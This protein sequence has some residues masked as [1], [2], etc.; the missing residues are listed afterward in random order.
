M[1]RNFY[2]RNF[3][4]A[5]KII[6]PNLYLDDD[7]DISGVQ[8]KDTDLLINSHILS[9]KNIQETLKLSSSAL[10]GS[11][12]YS[13]INNI[14][15]F[16]QFF[17]KQNKLTNI[18]PEKFQRKILRPMGQKLSS[19]QS[20][21]DFG[22]YVS[23]TLLPKIYL[24][25]TNIKTDT[26]S[27]FGG[28]QLETTEYVISN[29][30]WLYFLNTSAPA[31]GSFAPSTLVASSIVNTLW[32]N[33]PYRLN[34][35]IKDYQTYLWENFEGSSVP[36]EL[37][38]DKF[39]SD[40]GT[41]TSG[42][43][44]LNKLH[45]L[46]DVIYS[47]L[48]IDQEDK[49]VEEAF[50]TYVSATTLLTS[51]EEAGPFHKFL[52]GASLGMYDVNAQ[53][54]GLGDLASIDDCPEEY[55]PLLANLIGWKLYGRN[56]ESW[57]NQLKNAP[58]I[59][60][61]KGTKQGIIDSLNS[62]IPQNPI[63]SSG[64]ITELY[65]SYLPNLIYYCLATGSNLF[66]FDTYTQE[67]AFSH[68]AD[69]YS[70]TDKDYN[71]RV[72]VDNIL[73]YLVEEK[74]DNFIVQNEAFRVTRLVTGKAW[75]G[76][77]IEIAANVWTTAVYG[78][79]GE[80]LYDPKSAVDVDILADP[81]FVFNYRNRD[82]VLPPWEEEKFYSNCVIDD[83]LLA[84]LKT[85]LKSFCVKVTL[86]DSLIEYARDFVIKGSTNTDLYIGNSFIF[87][88]S[89]QHYPP[90][91]A[92]VFG[93]YKED[94]YDYLT[95][96]N[97]KSSLFDFTVSGGNFDAD[98]FQDASGRHTTND[99]L[100]S[101][102]IVDD[103][104]PA[105]AI[106]RV[107]FT[108]AAAE[109]ASG[110][111]FACPSV[112]VG[113]TNYGTSNAEVCG[114]YSRGRYGGHGSEIYPDFTDNLKRTWTSHKDKSTFKRSQFNYRGGQSLYA[115]SIFA[116]DQVV[117]VAS[118]VGRFS[119]RRRNFYNALDQKEWFNRSGNNMP[120]FYN[121]LG[122]V[123]TSNAI[124]DFVKLGFTPSSM[125]FAPPTPE[126]LSGVYRLDCSGSLSTIPDV[127]FGVA[128]KNTF[129]C[130]SHDTLNFS[131]CD[132]YVRR[133]RIPEE[134]KLF[135]DIHEEKKRSIAR[136][137]VTSNRNA[138]AA[139]A[140]WVNF[141]NSFANTIEDTGYEKYYSQTLNRRSINQK[142]TN[143]IYN[144]YA[145]Y[146]SGTNNAGLPENLAVNYRKGGANIL[147][148]T[149]GPIYRNSA[150]NYDGSALEVSSQFINKSIID[151]FLINLAASASVISNKIGLNTVNS[152]TSLNLGG[153][154]E[155]STK[156]IL[157]GINFIDTST[158]TLTPTNQFGI[159]DLVPQDSGLVGRPSYLENNRTVLMRSRS[160]GLPR[161]R[162]GLRGSDEKNV[163]VP[164][165]EYS[166]TLNY[167]TGRDNSSFIGGGSVGVLLHTKRE[168][169]SD[170][171]GVCFVWNKNSEWEQVY[172]SDLQSDTSRELILNKYVHFF[173]DEIRNEGERIGAC[174]DDE[175]LNGLQ[176]I[177]AESFSQAS[178]KFHTINAKT[179][180]TS[181][182]ATNFVASLSSV[183]NGES[184]QVHK[185]SI[186]D[187]NRSQNYFVNVLA[188][189]TTTF[190]DRFV[191][192][193][194]IDMVNE[195]LNNA[196]KV[197]YKAT[198]PDTSK[199]GETYESVTIL[200]P[201]GLELQGLPD[202]QQPLNDSNLMVPSD[203]EL[204]LAATNQSYLFNVPPDLA[205]NYRTTSLPFYLSLYPPGG[206]LL[207]NNIG[208]YYTYPYT[209][210]QNEYYT[211]SKRG[212]NS[213]FFRAS[214]LN[215]G[216]SIYQIR[217]WFR[218]EYLGSRSINLG[219]RP[220]LPT[221]T[222]DKQYRTFGSVNR[223]CDLIWD[224]QQSLKFNSG[225]VETDRNKDRYGFLQPTKIIFDDTTNVGLRNGIVPPDTM[226]NPL[227]YTVQEDTLAPIGT[228][229][230]I[231]QLLPVG[232]PIQS[233]FHS[234]RFNNEYDASP[235]QTDQF[236][237]EV[238]E[239][240]LGKY[241][242]GTMLDAYP[243]LINDL[244]VINKVNYGLSLEQNFGGDSS[245]VRDFNLDK[246]RPVPGYYQDVPARDLL[247][248][249]TYSFSVYLARPHDIT[250]MEG[251]LAEPPLDDYS[252]KA[253]S[254][255]ITLAP[256][257][258]NSS[259]VRL[260]INLNTE[261][262]SIQKGGRGSDLADSI[263]AT[264]EKVPYTVDGQ[265][266]TWYKLKVTLTYDATEKSDTYDLDQDLWDECLSQDSRLA[267]DGLRCSVFAY[268]DQY[269]N[270]L[271]TAAGNEV[272]DISSRVM[273]W[274]PSLV[275]G[276]AAGY[277]ERATELLP[278][279]T[280]P[281]QEIETIVYNV[282]GN[283][284]D[285]GDPTRK[286]TLFQ[287]DDFNLSYISED[288]EKLEK[289]TVAI[290]SPGSLVSPTTLY[291]K[292]FLYDNKQKLHSGPIYYDLARKLLRGDIYAA[293]GDQTNQ[294]KFLTV[295]GGGK[296]T[297]ITKEIESTFRIKPRQLLHLFRY[298]N[299]LGQVDK[300]EGFLTR[301]PSDSAAMH[302]VSGGSRVAYRSHP[303]NDT[304]GTSSTD[305]HSFSN[306]NIIG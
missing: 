35:A 141:E 207:W 44:N 49:R 110:A 33:K 85:L 42:T 171:S 298:F 127:Y 140:S 218:T 294:D 296:G 137:I 299:N 32:N 96:W 215:A 301:V 17:V 255:M 23:G 286:R 275:K 254:A 144:T 201:N 191:L 92:E 89:G 223:W 208:Q 263:A 14:D 196:A 100:Q 59:Y 216:L 252:D 80:V 142:G 226:K 197:P 11:N 177:T 209:G 34:D 282:V 114:V 24:N 302:N 119:L 125:G 162:Y 36:F 120:S 1:A 98:V 183:Y 204:S 69:V 2:K 122:N 115:S 195:T 224:T 200:R 18:T 38:P 190:S 63:N 212:W 130:R 160:H 229:S 154:A 124:F 272:I 97:G 213:D 31:G 25:N 305:Y 95:L 121:A 211:N 253:T 10:T 77:V 131:S 180:T 117:P 138:L 231:N 271:P 261:A 259:Y 273:L 232:T 103:M 134:V 136:N 278:H 221:E 281:A 88:T 270:A 105:K 244:N 161:L 46:I 269:D 139:S 268:N 173:S 47:P 277:W 287:D 172:V 99:I 152:E 241:S 7:Y 156:H 256:L 178:I 148:H 68:G 233:T 199:S 113:F 9:A 188:A 146:F 167:L 145:T 112:R 222:P 6:T 257:D 55:L 184:V 279:P 237:N 176:A 73:R 194:S 52:K 283:I 203:N 57:R 76:P 248:E 26:S 276:T 217:D 240:P 228:D 289:L 238:I 166:L 245:L 43:Q 45:T 30:N 182:Y 179:T 186:S 284:L 91:Q 247:N 227:G 74:A 28:T 111:D 189:P 300:G 288:T 291:T 22:D 3:V 50:Q 292:P 290:P 304:I 242:T 104:A 192:V 251:P 219:S 163:L 165:S 123:T 54:E 90:N 19:F 12:L 86:I 48:A 71:I 206:G 280:I 4:D 64:A 265:T 107:R 135:F 70:P 230:T 274:G 210:M 225:V 264:C 41:Y 81:N 262:S 20:S 285:I 21:S 164:E 133:D 5:V 143:Y 202:I 109:S 72:A 62:V 220:F 193:D 56:A 67:V 15:G 27:Y 155:H 170:G 108:K 126:N 116:T 40:T 181:K 84:T 260:N 8:V 158:A 101:L 214:L 159:F 235:H 150:F 61:K 75:F 157:S 267:N 65:E 169:D 129:L 295:S 102:R 306:I 153:A 106:P 58:S 175:S 174:G 60:R 87:Y 293:D 266:L 297:F 303:D 39:K 243:G 168:I 258:S 37:I 83:S 13:S 149:Y 239:R 205:L 147:S 234:R 185:A 118:G 93:Q 132:N 94:L 198:I 78:D 250:S 79:Q 16:S 51:T 187:A 151:P 128:S 29:L 246:H 249:Q 66:D 236:L 82:F 53:V